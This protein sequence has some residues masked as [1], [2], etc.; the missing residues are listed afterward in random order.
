MVSVML[1][2]V[3]VAD[4]EDDVQP[5]SVLSDTFDDNS[6]RVCTDRSTKTRHL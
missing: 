1:V 6:A 5:A 4:I 2:V 3:V